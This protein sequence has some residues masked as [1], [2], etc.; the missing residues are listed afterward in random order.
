MGFIQARD[1]NI[2][3]EEEGEGRPIVLTHLA[4]LRETAYRR[5]RRQAT[6]LVRASRAGREAVRTARSQT[7][8]PSEETTPAAPWMRAR[9]RKAA[10]APDIS[11]P[12]SKPSVMPIDFI[13]SAKFSFDASTT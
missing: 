13:T 7:P 5:W 10:A 2:Y 12:T 4:A 9:T 8:D 1:S 3:H 11:S 6:T